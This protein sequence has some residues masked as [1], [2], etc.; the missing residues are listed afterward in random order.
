MASQVA[1]GWNY[2]EGTEERQEATEKGKRGKFIDKDPL[3]CSLCSPAVSL[4]PLWFLGL[5]LKSWLQQI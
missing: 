1:S 3:D 4:R 2:T 5:K